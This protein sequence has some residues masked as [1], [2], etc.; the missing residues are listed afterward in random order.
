MSIVTENAI[1]ED[2][3]PYETEQLKIAKRGGKLRVNVATGKQGNFWVCISPS[4]NVSSY[5]KTLDE[6]K[7]GFV[8]NILTF[9]EDLLDLDIG[10]RNKVLREMGWNKT[11][12]VRRQFSKV[13]IDENGVLQ[14]LENPQ[15]LSL[16]TEA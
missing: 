1:W 9:V 16:E 12:I 3:F 4:L 8:E 14:G 10:I 2:S 13:F 6:A 7:Q 15:L 11:K 5:G